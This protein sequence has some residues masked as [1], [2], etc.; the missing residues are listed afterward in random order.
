MV[1]T[2]TDRKE[3]DVPI[4]GLPGSGFACY[5]GGLDVGVPP[6]AEGRD[7]RKCGRMHI[8]ALGDLSI[9]TG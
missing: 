5:V 8:D 6:R 9:A 2:R 1:G 3:D 4:D 7:V